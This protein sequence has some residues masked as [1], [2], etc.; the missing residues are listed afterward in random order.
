MKLRCCPFCGNEVKIDEVISYNKPK[1]YCILC[2][3]CCLDMMA[4]DETELVKRWNSRS[5]CAYDEDKNPLIVVEDG[6]V[7]VDKLKEIN[8]RPIVYKQGTPM[9]VIIQGDKRI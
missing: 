2:D 4:E 6:S 9:P 1:R 7:D 8:L 5:A 3:T